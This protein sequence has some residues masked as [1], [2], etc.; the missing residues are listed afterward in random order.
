MRGD[1][2]A[3]SLML[4]TCQSKSPRGKKNASYSDLTLLVLGA[5]KA[6]TGF[7]FFVSISG[8]LSGSY[9]AS[10]ARD[11]LIDDGLWLKGS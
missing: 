7:L 11:I 3:F 8:S 5:P 10:S 6:W 9:G 4:E 2:V 1:L